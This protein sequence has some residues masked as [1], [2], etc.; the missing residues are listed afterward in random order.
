MSTRRRPPRT[1]DLRR[2]SVSQSPAPATPAPARTATA[3]A[4]GPGGVT[5]AGAVSAGAVCGGGASG[6]RGSSTR[7]VEPSPGVAVHLDRP[8]VGGGDG[9]DDRQAQAG[10]AVGPAAGRRRCGR[11]ARRPARPARGSG[12]GRGRRPRATP[13]RGRRGVGTVAT[14]TVTG[15]PGGRV[16]EGVVEQV[17]D[18][19]VQARRRRPHDD[20]VG[21]S[22]HAVTSRSGAAAA[23]RLDGRRR[24]P[25]PGRPARAAAAAAGRAGPAAAGRRPAGPCV[26][27]R[28]RCGRAGG[29]PPRGR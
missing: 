14:R 23:G 27:P 28:P 3:A 19:L 8:A 21:G 24:P 9:G 6:D 18:H 20:R 29:T 11:S 1:I 16:G 17:G 25:R 12:P 10:A 15:V 7:N 22:V 2:P 26:S 5:S 13:G 4:P